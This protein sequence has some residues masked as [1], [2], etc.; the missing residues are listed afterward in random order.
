MLLYVVLMSL[1]HEGLARYLFSKSNSSIDTGL[2]AGASIRATGR[3]VA[4]LLTSAQRFQS[5]LQHALL[6][7]RF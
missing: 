6:E 7:D 3:V 5:L 2:T 1:A 4:S